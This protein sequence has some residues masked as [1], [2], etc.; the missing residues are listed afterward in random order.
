MSDLIK[1]LFDKF[2]WII[3]ALCIIDR[4]RLTFD[5]GVD[6]SKL[7]EQAQRIHDNDIQMLQSGLNLDERMAKKTLKSLG[8]AGVGWFKE[9]KKVKGKYE[10]ID[11]E[12]RG[13]FLMK[14][15]MVDKVVL[16]GAVL[17]ENGKRLY[18]PKID[19]E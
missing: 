18:T 7:E 1:E 8:E 3:V 13:Y 9:I 6:M 17:F 4:I 15:N 5:D 16:E 14:D 2:G 19:E 12:G 10:F 11:A